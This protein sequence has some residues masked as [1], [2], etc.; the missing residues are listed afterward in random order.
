MVS[1][2]KLKL[3][4]DVYLQHGTNTINFIKPLQKHTIYEDAYIYTLICINMYKTKTAW[5]PIHKFLLIAYKSGRKHWKSRKVK[6]WTWHRSFR[7]LLFSLKW[8]WKPLNDQF[9]IVEALT[10]PVIPGFF[11]FSKSKCSCRVYYNLC[12]KML[13]VPIH[14]SVNASLAI[15][16]MI[17]Y[18]VP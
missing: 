17:L 10:Q 13:A 9:S 8:L 16:C 3:Q 14:S 4:S 1:E 7:F 11:T 5:E 12:C 6:T 2:K 18:L 15:L